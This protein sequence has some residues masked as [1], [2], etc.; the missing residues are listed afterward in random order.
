MDV[1][2]LISWYLAQSYGSVA[3]RFDD[4]NGIDSLLHD[5]FDDLDVDKV[6]II[7]KVFSKTRVY[8]S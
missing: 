3:A 4:T 7:G 1:Y 8:N 2:D 5:L 6:C